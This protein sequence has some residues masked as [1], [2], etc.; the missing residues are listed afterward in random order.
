MKTCQN[1]NYEMSQNL[2]SFP[3][4]FFSSYKFSFIP[5]INSPGTFLQL[6]VEEAVQMAFNI[7]DSSK[8]EAQ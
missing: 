5:K 6:V 8:D 4:H 7:L 3:T 1:I 2:T